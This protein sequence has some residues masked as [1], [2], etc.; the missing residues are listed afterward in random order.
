MALLAPSPCALRLM[1]KRCYQ[2]AQSHSLVSN[3]DKTQLVCFGSA[4]Q[5][6]PNFQ[7]LGHSLKFCSTV[8]HL[9]HVSSHD[10][11]DAPDTSFHVVTGSLNLHFAR[12]FASHCLVLL[13]GP[14]L[15]PSS[16]LWKGPL[17]ISC[18][19]SGVCLVGATPVFCTSLLLSIVCL[20]L[21]TI[22]H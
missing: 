1:L 5:C 10:F 7:F 16:S 13:S 9:G 21:F 12:A 19:R 8:R 3:A 4:V 17:I 6:T 11:S 18:V 2:F 14:S 20:I 15:V 22:D